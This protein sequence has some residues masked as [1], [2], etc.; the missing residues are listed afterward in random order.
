MVERPT[1]TG[2]S[3]WCGRGGAHGAWADVRLGRV[4]RLSAR[5]VVRRGHA[6]L[7]G[8]LRASGD[9]SSRTGTFDAVGDRIP[10]TERADCPRLERTAPGRVECPPPHCPWGRVSSSVDSSRSVGPGAEVAA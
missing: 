9:I 1:A 3:C 2:P 7:A 8:A 6:V 10:V 4:W 5:G